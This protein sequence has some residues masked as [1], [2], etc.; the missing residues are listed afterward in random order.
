[1]FKR[2]VYVSACSWFLKEYLLNLTRH[3]N[4]C[5]QIT[6]F[7]NFQP[8]TFLL[9]LFLFSKR[10]QSISMKLLDFM[11]DKICKKKK[12]VF[13]FFFCFFR[14]RDNTDFM[15]W[16]VQ[17]FFSKSKQDRTLK[18]LV[19]IGSFNYIYS[20]NYKYS[21]AYSNVRCLLVIIKWYI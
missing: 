11:L 18:W 1:M 3:L 21:F 20:F 17:K 16:L 19:I 15:F 9:L 12:L 6:I 14:S 2:V 7:E 8:K 5:T 13:D 10:F 4:T